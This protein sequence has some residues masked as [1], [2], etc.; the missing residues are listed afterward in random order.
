ME[1][2]FFMITRWLMLVGTTIAF[3][4]LIFGGIYAFNLYN[5][6]Q[7]T[8]VSDT[9]YQP[10]NPEVSFEEYKRIQNEQIN[11]QRLEK[12]KIK[13]YVLRVITNGSKGHGFPLGSMPSNMIKGENAK[14]VAEYIASNLSTNKPEA[15]GACAACHGINGKGMNGRSPSLLKLPIYNGLVAKIENE[16]E[17]APS[18]S[19]NDVPQYIEPLMRYTSKIAGSINKY[20][21]LVGQEGVEVIKLFDFFNGL[22]KKYTTQDFSLLKEQLSNGLNNLLQYGK[23]YKKSQ[24]NTNEAIVWKEYISWFINDFDAQLAQEAKKY[25]NSMHEI[26]QKKNQKLNRSA[27]AERELLQVL[28]GLGTVLLTFI[29]LTMILVLFKIESNTRKNNNSKNI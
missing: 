17:Y 27:E 23:A 1:K 6:S 3:V 9:A 7:D 26:E 15:F 12:K 5:I 4:A 18:E 19:N 20:A 11:R 21:I 2:V 29:L 8:H 16:T 14:V 28:A 22:S 24:K 25:E 13:Q 10:K